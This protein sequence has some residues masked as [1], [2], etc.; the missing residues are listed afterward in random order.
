[1]LE[2]LRCEDLVM[3]V[4]V[5][6][7]SEVA[8]GSELVEEGLEVASGRSPVVS[9]VSMVLDPFVCILAAAPR[10]VIAASCVYNSRLLVLYSLQQNRAFDR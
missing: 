10:T 4:F 3:V 9:M 2:G 5:M 1:M 6:L 8:S 7:V